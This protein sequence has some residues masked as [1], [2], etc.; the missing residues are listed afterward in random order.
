MNRRIESLDAL[1]GLAALSVVIFHCLISFELFHQANYNEVYTSG[2]M[3]FFAES[4]LRLLWAGKEA[5]LLFFV[6]SGFVLAIPFMNNRVKSYKDYALK[7]FTR[8]YIPY[9]CVMIISVILAMLFLDLKPDLGLS[10]TYENRWDHEVSLLALVSYVLMLNYDT[11]NVNGVVWTLF[12]EMRISLIFPIIMFFIMK[13]KGIKSAV[14]SFG[15]TIVA[16]F[17]FYGVAEIF[18]IEVVG[19]VIDNFGDSF[20]YA[21]FFVAGALLSKYRDVITSALSSKSAV[22]RFILFIVAIML[23]SYKWMYNFID[24]SGTPLTDFIPGIGILILFAVTLSSSLMDRILTLKPLLWLGKISYS[25]YLTHVIVIMICTIL[26]SNFMP[27]AYTFVI[28]IALSL[29]VAHITYKL[30]EEP[31]I[32]IGRKITKKSRVPNKHIEKAVP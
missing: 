27:V 17:L 30:F 23:I 9:I 24:F 15:F 6:L 8:I 31:S 16:M 32:A 4:P 22:Y 3:K 2:L 19:Q 29:P 13:F 20:Y 25:L 7:R 28:A 21:L 5:V 1:R 26:L 12:H 18:P 11:A 14:F 10:S